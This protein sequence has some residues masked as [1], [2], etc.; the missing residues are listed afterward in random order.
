MGT[1]RY[2]KAVAALLPDVHD[3]YR[4]YEVPGLGHCYGGPSGQPSGLFAQLRA[5]VENGTAPGQSPIELRGL[6]GGVH[7]RIV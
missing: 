3:F 1:E 2:Y 6:D 4:H 7:D 5:W